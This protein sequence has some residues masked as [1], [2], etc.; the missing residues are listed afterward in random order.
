MLVTD[1]RHFR[2]L[3]RF[4]RNAERKE[5]SPKRNRYNIFNHCPSHAGWLAHSSLDHLVRPCEDVRRNREADLLR[6]L[7]VN[8]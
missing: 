5:Q 8:D 4:A 3:L 1:P 2:R 6:R 7:K